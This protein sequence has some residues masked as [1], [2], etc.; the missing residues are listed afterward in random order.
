MSEEFFAYLF[1]VFLVIVGGI[2]V[3]VTAK[4]AEG[5]GSE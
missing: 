1:M 2:V 4:S 3:Y 5:K